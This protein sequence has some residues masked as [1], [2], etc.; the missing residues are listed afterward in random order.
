MAGLLCY[1][2]KLKRFNKKR[3]FYKSFN[4]KNTKQCMLRETTIIISYDSIEIV[5]KYAWTILNFAVCTEFDHTPSLAHQRRHV[6]Y[7]FGFMNTTQKL[8]KNI[9][10]CKR[11]K[12]WITELRDSATIKD[13]INLLLE[14]A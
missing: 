8:D 10:I 9:L 7:P 4:W 2:S 11:T 12:R 6:T 1:L 5:Q 3:E 14:M 13:P